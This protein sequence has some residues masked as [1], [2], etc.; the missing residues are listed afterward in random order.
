MVRRFSDKG[1]W[2]WSSDSDVPKTNYAIKKSRNGALWCTCRGCKF[3]KRP[4]SLLVCK[5]IRQYYKKKYATKTDKEWRS[6]TQ[7][8]SSIT[9][10]VY[11]DTVNG[12]YV[13]E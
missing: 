11:I 1:P 12:E 9:F 3:Q 8:L 4:V 7:C 5:H 13:I 10:V 6:V 2:S